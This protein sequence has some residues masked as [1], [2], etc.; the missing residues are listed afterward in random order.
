MDLMYIAPNVRESP[1]GGLCLRVPTR[2]VERYCGTVGQPPRILCAEECISS[3]VERKPLGR[4]R[5]LRTRTGTMHG[6]TVERH[7]LDMREFK[8]PR[9]SLLL[10]IRT[11]MTSPAHAL[12]LNFIM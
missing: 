1:Y 4:R 12:F 8:S 10:T 11:H 3:T 2:V 9:T 7:L 5:T 6:G